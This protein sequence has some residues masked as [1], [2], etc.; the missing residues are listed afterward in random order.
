MARAKVVVDPDFVF[1]NC[2]FSDD[3]KQLFQCML[4]TVVACGFRPRTALEAADGGDVRLDKI[5]RLVRESSYSIHD[6]S[7]VELDSVNNLPRFNMPFELGMVI[8]CKKL[9]GRSYA[10]RSLLILEHTRYTTQKCLSDI[11]GQDPTAHNGNPR[12]LTRVVRNWLS[13]ESKRTNIPGERKVFEAYQRF[14]AELSDI[15][16]E[17]G[18][19]IETLNYPDL[20]GFI[21]EWLKR[22]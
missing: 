17:A 2:P 16:N 20:L 1:I 10:S 15:C 3:F 7:A 14:D 8:G 13:Q 5:V 21:Q 22:Q 11:A 6:L 9:A 12:T 4:F 18:L 19:D